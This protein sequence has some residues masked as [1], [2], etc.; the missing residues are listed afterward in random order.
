MDY[1]AST[2]VDQ[3]LKCIKAKSAWVYLIVVEL[4]DVRKVEEM[5][6]K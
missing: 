5:L 4:T 6:E 1:L 2:A 3:D